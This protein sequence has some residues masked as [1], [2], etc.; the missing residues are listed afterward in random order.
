M[1]WKYA[2]YSRAHLL[3][4][5][6]AAF[7]HCLAQF[8][9]GHKIRFCMEVWSMGMMA[10]MI[11]VVPLGLLKMQHFQPW[12][13]SL[14]LCVQC[15]LHRRLAT[16]SP[17]ILPHGGNPVCFIRD[18]LSGGCHFT[19][20]CPWTPPWEVGVSVGQCSSETTMFGHHLVAKQTIRW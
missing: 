14:Q 13:Q 6:E 19:R 17:C 2:V 11:A 7:Y 5:R 10:S 8:H 15:H 9:L 18:P 12:A 4:I 1:G 20:W 3:E 16:D